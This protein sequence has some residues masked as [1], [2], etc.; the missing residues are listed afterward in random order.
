MRRVM[1]GFPNSTYWEGG[2]EEEEGEEE[3]GEEEGEEVNLAAK[4][5]LIARKHCTLQS[6]PSLSFISDM[7]GLLWGSSS[8][9]LWTQTK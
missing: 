2:R 4:G 7:V 3:E 6:C 8:Q 1:R 9:Q 5:Q